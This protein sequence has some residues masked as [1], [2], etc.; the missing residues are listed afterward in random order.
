MQG[1]QLGQVPP[2]TGAKHESSVTLTGMS[3]RMK[4]GERHFPYSEFGSEFIGALHKQLPKPTHRGLNRW[5]PV[6]PA[7]GTSLAA[8]GVQQTRASVNIALRTIPAIRVDVDMPGRTC[9]ACGHAVVLIGDRDIASDVSDALIEAF[10]S[11]AIK[12]G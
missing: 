6:C 2:I 12:P 4:K 1:E 10:Q 11:E 7:C 5:T 9:P 3:F 8:A